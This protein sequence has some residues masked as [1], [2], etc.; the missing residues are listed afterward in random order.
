MLFGYPPP[1]KKETPTELE[2]ASF[3]QSDNLLERSTAA[4]FF[5]WVF[6]GSLDNKDTPAGVKK[7][8]TEVF[9]FS[10]HTHTHTIQQSKVHL[11]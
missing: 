1:K 3:L 11:H 10:I 4:L 9:F 8:P 2:P 6:V 7:T 5:F